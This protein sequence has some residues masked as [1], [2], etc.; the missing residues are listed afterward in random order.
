MSGPATS[1][2]VSLRQLTLAAACVGLALVPH[3][4]TLPVWVLLLAAAAAGLRLLL[5]AAGRDAPPSLL[6]AAI[7]A[8]C[9]GLLF[10]QFRT[11]NGL[12]AGTALLTMMAGLKLLETRTYR[13]IY[14]VILIGYFLSLAALL[15][16]SSFWLLSYLIGV[17][18]LT[19]AMLLRL[20]TSE[21]GQDW[22]G[23]LRYAGRILLQAVPLTLVLWLFFPRF[24]GPLWQIPDDGRAAA[25]GLSDTMSPGDIT[26]LALSD[27]VA[28]R[29]RY[30][31]A[32][33]PPRE[34]YFRGPVLHDFDGHTWRRSE[35]NGSP[36]SRPRPAG[37]A[38]R[39]SVSLEPH[40]HRWIY[41]LDWPAQWDLPRAALTDDQ[42][43][44]EPNPV[45]QALDYDATSYSRVQA[46]GNL[47][48]VQRRRDTRLPLGPNP[49]ARALS[50]GMRAANPDDLD[51]VHAV[52]RMFHD[53][54][55]FYTLTP[56][57]LD[58]DSVDRFLFDSRRG[59][60]GHYASAFA[61]LMRAANIPARVVTGYQGGVPN[62]YGD[63]WILRQ[64]DA[65]AWDEVWVG[66]GWLRVDPT[67]WIAPERVERSGLERQ[68]SDEALTARHQGAAPWVGDLRLRMDALRELWRRRI[69]DF[70]QNSQQSLLQLLDIPQPDAEKLVL[71]LS[72]ALTAA[73]GW[74]TWQ[75]RR[76]LA[77]RQ[78]DR[79][80][81]AYA[82][83]CRKL[84]AAGLPRG[85][86]E[87]AESYAERIA[88]TRPDI[89]G[90]MLALGRA[91]SALRYGPTPTAGE[92]AH[93]HAAVR[94]FRVRRRAGG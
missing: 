80:G 77:P 28:F 70:N 23:S 48:T 1:P 2:R 20:T 75:V 27:D 38:Y 47:G 15:P 83:L 32:V 64:S 63:Y 44:I 22:Y 40:G 89:A 31:G 7:A 54:P 50:A 18:W 16:G 78:R 41:A 62:R 46:P 91:Y 30:E 66:T 94:G 39:Y 92:I 45:T 72:I 49:R 51:F 90:E 9:I 88:R 29:V 19:T 52:L 3:L 60:C 4:A 59:F 93:F 74:L 35:P 79:L 84:A 73:L 67:A 6:R 25:S 34:R 76:E 17:C 24:A 8:L 85:A 57:K 10:L 58:D 5:A 12:S 87:G 61:V 13:D 65:H 56:P 81:R 37:P 69:L 11:F 42:M 43:L 71:V 33:P 82:A 68:G 26:D 55:F 53:E 21:P 14:V 36:A 86:A